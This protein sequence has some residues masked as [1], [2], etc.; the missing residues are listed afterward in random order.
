M[1][2]ALRG[3]DSLRRLLR[4][5]GDEHTGKTEEESPT[6]RLQKLAR[7]TERGE[8]GELSYETRDNDDGDETAASPDEEIGAF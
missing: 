3:P 5:E 8:S 7:Q 2:P 6:E 1:P 4:A